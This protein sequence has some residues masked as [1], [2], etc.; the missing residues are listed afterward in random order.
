MP[1]KKKDDKSKELLTKSP[2]NKMAD[3][4]RDGLNKI[5][6]SF[7]FTTPDIKD[8]REDIRRNIDSALDSIISNNTDVSGEGNV[9]RLLKRM[10]QTAN[11]SDTINAFK[12]LFEDRQLMS[13][14]FTSYSQNRYLY[15][16]DAEIDVIIKYMPK[17]KEALL[18][19]KDNVLS[20]DHFSKDFINAKNISDLSNDN[21]FERRMNELKMY[22]NLLDKFEDWYFKTSMYGETFIYIVPYSRG[23]ANIMKDKE[24]IAIDKGTMNLESFEY[25]FN[26]TRQPLPSKFESVRSVL[27]EIGNIEIEINH[28]NCIQ[29]VIQE[30]VQNYKQIKSF[31]EQSMETYFNEEVLL[32]E[33]PPKQMTNASSNKPIAID[34][35]NVAKDDKHTDSNLINSLQKIKKIKKKE[36][37]IPDDKIDDYI[38]SIDKDI[39]ADDGLI[40]VGLDGKVKSKT[41][42][43]IP[44]AIVKELDRHNVIPIM[45]DTEICLGYY[46]FEFQEKRDF[47]INSSMRLSDPM[48]TVTNGNNFASENDRSEHDK[49]LRYI[50]S[51]ISKYI[52]SKFVNRNQDLKKEIYAILKYNQIYNN[53]N[54]NKMRVTFI[55]TDDIEHIYFEIDPY[56]R[57]GRSDLHESMLP[58][59]LYTAMY[60]TTSIMSM[61]RGYDKR[62]YYVNPGIE[63]NLTEAMFNVI[64]QIKQG[65]FGIRQIRN[66]LNQVLNIQGRFNDYFILKSPNGESPINMEVISGQNVEIKT[67]LMNML[68][69]MSIN[70]TNVP[71][72]LVQTRMNSMDYAIQL[73]MSSSKFLRF[74]FKRQSKVNKKFGRI[75]E[76][77]YNYH[78]KKNDMLDFTLPPP[79]FLSVT[80]NTQFFE[81]VNNYATQVAEMTWDGDPNDEFGKNTYIKEIKKAMTGSYYNQEFMDK[82]LK[83]AKQ[84]AA[85]MP[86][87]AKQP[88]Q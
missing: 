11:S 26:G 28:S 17:L 45:V 70:P 87:T 33:K 23:I 52:D 74:I 59:K 1:D 66:N 83:K 21:M 77:I 49:A 15:D 56:N 32:E 9:S 72:E 57:R 63:A 88:G 82:I 10:M 51:E 68:E 27:K 44:G 34:D 41:K 58:A 37:L 6:Q 38:K 24:N 40:S 80:N 54:P 25:N 35:Y 30:T 78:Y 29:S 85:I 76:K 65:N 62:V 13:S 55:P 39:S 84:I 16:Y 18:I 86:M 61:T 79:T 43:D 47:L 71:V 42:F 36:P 48:M 50:A 12:N 53:P 19:M 81:N 14:V 75:L 64:N 20:T 69:E 4:I 3:N 8:S 7:R 60:I 73:T 5:Y 22:Y 67:E 31:N 2:F 46:Y